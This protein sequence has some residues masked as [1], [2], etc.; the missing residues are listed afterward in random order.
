[1]NSLQGYYGLKPTNR[2]ASKESR[3]LVDA[4]I[5]EFNQSSKPSKE[6]R[7]DKPMRDANNLKLDFSLRENRNSSSRFA[8][9]V[10][11]KGLALRPKA[12]SRTNLSAV[13]RVQKSGIAGMMKT[14]LDPTD[15]LR[16]EIEILRRET[17]K[18]ELRLRPYHGHDLASIPPHELEGLEQQLEHSVRKVRERKK[19]LLQQ[20]LGNLSRK[21][22]MLEDDNNNMY[23]WLHDEHR[24]GVEFQQAGIETKPMEYQQFLEQVQYYNDHHQQQSSVLQ[25]PT[26][27]SEIDLSYHLQLA[28]PN[29]QNDPTA[30]VD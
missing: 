30:K 14:A 1:M 4:V 13:N 23:R 22:R 24:T 12:A 15:D 26:L 10:A 19:E 7:C 2:R 21:K 11:G 18:L 27:P 17:C 16:H 8:D 28:Q 3:N 29:L 5:S 9:H 25:L 20:Q 6:V